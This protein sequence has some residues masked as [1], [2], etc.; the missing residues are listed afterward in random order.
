MSCRIEIF[1]EQYALKKVLILNKLNILSV[2]L[3]FKLTV[4]RSKSSGLHIYYKNKTVKAIRYNNLES[5]RVKTNGLKINKIMDKSYTSTYV[6]FI[7]TYS[8]INLF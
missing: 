7:S 1:F 5:Y 6:N 4:A 2:K 3:H 8:L